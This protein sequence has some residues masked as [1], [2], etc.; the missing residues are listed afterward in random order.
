MDAVLDIILLVNEAIGKV[1]N[2]EIWVLTLG[3]WV[4]GMVGLFAGTGVLFVTAI[5]V[6]VTI[7]HTIP[8]ATVLLWRKST[9]R[10]GATASPAKPEPPFESG[11]GHDAGRRRHRTVAQRPRPDTEE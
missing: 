11:S 6:Y 1:H 5:I 2:Q 7:F 4:A 9:A 8:Q 3:E 10:T